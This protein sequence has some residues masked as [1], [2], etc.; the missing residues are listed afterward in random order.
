M[1]D[2]D[3]LGGVSKIKKQGD[4]RVIVVSKVTHKEHIDMNVEWKI[5]FVG[6]EGILK[7]TRDRIIK[8]QARTAQAKN[9]SLRNFA[10][11]MVCDKNHQS[12]M[13]SP[14]VVVKNLDVHTKLLA[15]LRPCYMA[16]DQ[17]YAEHLKKEEGDGVVY[18]FTEYDYEKD[19]KKLKEQLEDKKAGY[20][21]KSEI[22][23]QIFKKQQELD[24]FLREKSIYIWEVIRERLG[25]QKERLGKQ[26]KDMGTDKIQLE[27]AMYDLSHSITDRAMADRVSEIASMIGRIFY[28]EKTNKTRWGNEGV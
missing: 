10:Y 5:R 11:Q 1:T 16:E 28:W 25:N 4:S 14:D 2:G 21:S 13:Y 24:A 18:I 12:E 20:Y 8:N 3:W 6:K 7:E 26:V 23:E 19:L 22:E 15:L 9:R 27:L 17:K